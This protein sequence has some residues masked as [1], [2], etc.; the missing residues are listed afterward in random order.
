[1]NVPT[2][3]QPF[4]QHTHRWQRGYLTHSIDHITAHSSSIKYPKPPRGGYY[5]QTVYRG[6]NWGT[7]MLEAANGTQQ[8]DSRLPRES[9]IWLQPLS[10]LPCHTQDP[11]D[12]SPRTTSVF[13]FLLPT[14]SIHPKI[15]NTQLVLL[16]IWF[17]NSSGHAFWIFQVLHLKSILSPTFL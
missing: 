2:P 8:T 3:M 13:I 4:M 16:C 7:A 9:H 10:Q 5:W 15:E 6:G 1:M 12:M 11:P 14:S 17:V